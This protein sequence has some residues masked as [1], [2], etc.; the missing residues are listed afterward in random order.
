MIVIRG[1]IGGCRSGWE[2]G[3]E[4]KFQILKFKIPW[5][6][7]WA[8]FSPAGD[9]AGISTTAQLP[10]LRSGDFAGKEIRENIRDSSIHATYTSR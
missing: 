4:E 6:F 9:F 1:G 10:L 2:R 3:Y 7:F 5:F 8:T